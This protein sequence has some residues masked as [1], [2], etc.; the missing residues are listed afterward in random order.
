MYNIL[1]RGSTL[2]HTHTLSRSP[3]EYVKI[4]LTHILAGAGGI[5]LGSSCS[6]Q[7]SIS[8]YSTFYFCQTIKVLLKSEEGAVDTTQCRAGHFRY[9]LDFFNNKKMIFCLYQVNLTVSGLFK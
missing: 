8:I 3:A 4:F 2:T 7:H 6:F 5:Y 9:F 1:S